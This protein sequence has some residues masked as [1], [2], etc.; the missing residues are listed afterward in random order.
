MER[1]RNTS[2]NMNKENIKSMKKQTIAL[3]ITVVIAFFSLITTIIQVITTYKIYLNENEEKLHIFVLPK[4]FK[5]FGK[6]SYFESQI[7]IY[8]QWKAILINNGKN[9]I[10][11]VDGS[12]SMERITNKVNTNRISWFGKVIEETYIIIK[13]GEI[14]SLDFGIPIGIDIKYKKFLSA[15]HYGNIYGYPSI[16]QN[17]KDAGFDFYKNKSNKIFTNLIIINLELVSSKEKH[18]SLFLDLYDNFGRQKKNL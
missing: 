4:D 9:P 13:P 3:I 10:S 18:F 12:I 15:N 17:L 14:C 11:L 8:T 5:N 1:K 6:I 7:Y 16:M 2:G